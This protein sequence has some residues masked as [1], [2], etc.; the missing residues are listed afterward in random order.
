MNGLKESNR[1]DKVPPNFL[2]SLGLEPYFHDP[3]S[4]QPSY[5]G[6]RLTMAKIINRAII[7]GLILSL[8]S[9]L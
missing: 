7:V 3:C 4:N 9:K 2:D 6:S 8:N 5:E 1:I